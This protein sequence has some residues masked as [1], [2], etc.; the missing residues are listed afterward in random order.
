MAT[1]VELPD[2]T[3]LEIPDGADPSAVAKAY[4]AKQQ[5]PRPRVTGERGT[6]AVKRELGLGARNILEGGMDVV[7]PFADL[8]GYGINKALPGDPLPYNHS[9]NFSQLLTRAGL[10]EPQGLGEKGV[11]L[12]SRIAVGAMAGRGIDKAVLGAM[13]EVPSA[14]AIQQ[15]SRQ[16][17]ESAQKEGLVVPPAQVAPRSVGAA[18]EGAGG[19]L[20]TGQAAAARNQP[21]INSLAARAVGVADETLTPEVLQS[22]R[23]QASDAY[24]V[25]RGAGRVVTDDDFVKQVQ[26]A[27]QPFRS[28]AQSF[29]SLA[30]KELV[31]MADDIAKP[32]FE[33]DAA[34][35]AI[36]MLRDKASVAYRAGSS[37]EGS[38]YKSMASALEG[39]IER[40]LSRQGEA[41]AEMLSSFRDARQLIAKTHTVEDALRGSN[42]DIAALGRML[43][44]GVPLTDELRLLGQF[45]QHF[46]GAA[47]ITRAAQN[48][49]AYSVL[50]WITGGSS[51]SA[52]LATGKP[53]LA[54]PAAIALARPGARSL[55]LSPMVQRQMMTPLAQKLAPAIPYA[56][57]AAPTLAQF[58]AQQQGKR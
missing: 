33:A 18:L 5:Q 17:L 51:L 4:L 28:A 26:G 32:S 49:P 7:A 52:A 21:I 57:G 8:I 16:V 25:I 13:G 19:T 30:N 20:K 6:A 37:G 23:N 2:G 43:K 46:P 15:P 40:H 47:N 50:D 44:K 14:A 27:V 1:E 10:P 31:A 53:E 36:K 24:R 55:A 42:V 54:V 11:N 41:G 56:L 9:Q 58:L 45:N 12:G 38:A 48:R 3:I 39:A 22:V 35:D 34:V 29:A